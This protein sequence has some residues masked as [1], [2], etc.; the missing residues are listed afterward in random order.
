[1]QPMQVATMIREIAEGAHRRGVGDAACFEWLAR[2]LIDPPEIERVRVFGAAFTPAQ[3]EPAAETPVPTADTATAAPPSSVG[4][5]RSFGPPFAF[6]DLRPCASWVFA[7]SDSI[8]GETI[9]PGRIGVLIR[10]RVSYAIVWV[11]IVGPKDAALKQRVEPLTA[12]LAAVVPALT[13]HLNPRNPQRLRSE[14]FVRLVSRSPEASERQLEPICRAWRDVSGAAFAWLWLHNDLT[15]DYELSCAVGESARPPLPPRRHAPGDGSLG[16]YASRVLRPVLVEDAATWTRRLNGDEYRVLMRDTLAEMGMRA[17]LCVPV[18]FPGA[19]QRGATRGGCSLVSLHAPDAGQFVAHD[20]EMLVLMG[21]ITAL[22][23][24]HANQS[25]QNSI[26]VDLNRIAQ[27]YLAQTGGRPVEARSKYLKELID[28]IRERLRVGAVSVFYRSGI[29]AQVECIASTGLIDVAANRPL[30]EDRLS[31]AR[32]AAGERNTGTCF[33]A[34]QPIIKTHEV[35]VKYRE[36]RRHTGGKAENPAIYVPIPDPLDEHK[37]GRALGVIR[38]YD[39]TSLVFPDELSNFDGK[40][41]ENLRF[42]AEQVGPVLRTFDKRIHRERTIGV[43]KHDLYAPL[44]MMRDTIEELIADQQAGRSPNPYH[45]KDLQVSTRVTSNL[46]EQLDPDPGAVREV[47][48]LPT[49]LEGDIVARLC[50]MMGHLAWKQKRMKIRYDGFR[51]VPKLRIDPVLVERAIY[52]LLSNAIKY[53]SPSSTIEVVAEKLENGSGYGVHVRNFGIGIEP[54]DRPHV[55]RPG[56]RARRA[57]QTAMGAG[58]GLSIARK[59]MRANGGEIDVTQ[60][61]NPTTFTLYF[62]EHLRVVG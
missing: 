56:F 48:A 60:L 25:Q 31:A 14:F 55:F 37:D 58:L 33:D 61:N 5:I 44:S 24:E 59:A 27:R 26:L 57:R 6:G 23:I 2:R 43:L 50:D 29:E 49:Y 51:E 18:C 22:C 32:Y 45:L 4:A 21:R 30:P 39:H 62:P 7:E 8:A 35:D 3:A 19:A 16:R 47:N 52:N 36:A 38:C 13:A 11:L 28:L 1:M 42:I 17:V 34:S 53:G 54:A 40:E 10:V 41:V 20:D 12:G 9:P 46:V 15:G